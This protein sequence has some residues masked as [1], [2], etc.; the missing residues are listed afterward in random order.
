M[1]KMKSFVCLFGM[2]A[3]LLM[4]CT[5]HERY[6][7]EIQR[8]CS[9]VSTSFQEDYGIWRRD[10]RSFILYIKK[11]TLTF[12][13]AYRQGISGFHQTLSGDDRDWMRGEEAILYLK[14]MQSLRIDDCWKEDGYVCVWA[15][16]T[17]KEWFFL[18]S[19]QEPLN[20]H[21]AKK[22]MNRK[23]DK[24]GNASIH[25]HLFWVMIEEHL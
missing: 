18:Y 22:R 20:L 13:P 25:D 14:E 2:C 21:E 23:Q 15:W 8:F 1:S 19:E 11:D 17:W 5:P 12:G 7:A 3:C 4:S 6:C 9:K 24:I 10:N 16:N